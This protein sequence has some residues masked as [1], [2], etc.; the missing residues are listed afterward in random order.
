LYAE[1]LHITLCSPLKATILKEY[2]A[3]IFSTKEQAIQ[4]TSFACCLLLHAGFLLSL[5]F[6]AED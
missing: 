6:N 5:L 3:S 4:E 2:V 1:V